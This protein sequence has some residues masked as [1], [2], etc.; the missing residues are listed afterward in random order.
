MSTN[1]IPD[2]ARHAVFYEVYPQS[3]QDTNGDGI[4]D[5]DGVIARLDYIAS[6]GADAIWLN[7]FYLSPMRDAGYDVQDYYQVDPRYGT[8]ETARRLFDEAKRRG[9]RVI[10]DFVPGH[11]SIDHPWFRESARPEAARPWRNW[12]IWTDSAW[13]DGGEPWSRKMVHGYCNRDGNFLTNFF[14]SQP[15]LN[16]GFAEPEADKPWQLPTTHED[17][18]ALWREMRRVL[19]FWLE[20]GAAGFRVDMANPVRNDPTHRENRRFWAET[21]AELEPDF[22]ELFLIAEASPIIMLDGRGFHSA[23]L[24]WEAGYWELFRKGESYNQELG[25]IK[26]DAYFDREGGGDFRKF[27]ATWR[28]HYAETRDHGVITVPVGNHDLTRVAVGQSIEELELIFAFQTAWP[29]IPFFYYGDEIGLPQQ[30]ADNPVHEGHYR[31]RNG[32]RTPMQ[33][34][35]SKNCGFSTCAPHQLYLPVDPEPGAATVRAQEADAGSLLHRV[36]RLN[37]LHRELPA[38]AADAPIEIL[39]EGSPGEPL[40]FWRGDRERVMCFYQPKAVPFAWEVPGGAA[41]ELIA[42]GGGPI[43]IGSDGSF[44][45]MG[46]A[47][48]FL[49]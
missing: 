49:R 45:G 13:N 6:V 16:F 23:F 15:A 18:Q 41:L 38:F 14:F 34:D 9:L 37:E 2:W 46:P 43:S 1:S 12:Y 8:N 25:R 10:I 30:S 5:L 31:T 39:S 32:A 47:W 7:P 40:A 11:T 28:E 24:H 29:G 20:L 17:V 4:G 35:D 3:F 19:R 22:P 48:G 33:W 27:L 26:T 44:S 36:R 42:G 21:R